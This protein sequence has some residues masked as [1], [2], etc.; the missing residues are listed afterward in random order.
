MRA[1]YEVPA[2]GPRNSGAGVEAAAAAAAA[3]DQGGA[4]GA[5]Q[6]YLSPLYVAEIFGVLESNK[7][8]LNTHE[9][10]RNQMTLERISNRIASKFMV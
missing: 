7:A 8:A 2:N 1:R 10:S 5:V 4:S 9:Y 6:A 3:Q